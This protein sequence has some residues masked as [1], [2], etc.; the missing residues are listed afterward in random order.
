MLSCKEVTDLA[1]RRQDAPLSLRTRVA[2]RLHLLICTMCSRYVQQLDF[3]R[4]VMAAYRERDE[5]SG[6]KGLSSEGRAKI[7]EAIRNES[8]DDS[9]K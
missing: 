8:T 6:I 5:P 7:R 9:K 4:R 3:I 2:M 1:S